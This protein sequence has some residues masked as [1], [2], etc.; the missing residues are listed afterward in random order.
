[1]IPPVVHRVVPPPGSRRTRREIRFPF[2]L[3]AVLFAFLLAFQPAV[4][5]RAQVS[6]GLRA[7]LAGQTALPDFAARLAAAADKASGVSELLV[8]LEEFVPK[9]Q[10]G[11]GRRSLLLRW[12]AVLAR[13]SVV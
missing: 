9:V 6:G 5:L 8:L 10:D 7:E 4:S 3:S 12:A 11:P 2:P 13:K 1:M